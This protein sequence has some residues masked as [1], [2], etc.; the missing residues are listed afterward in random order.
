VVLGPGLGKN[1]ETIETT[2]V[3]IK[4]IEK[5]R[6]PLLLDADGLKAFSGSKR[7]LLCPSV[8]TPHAKEFEILSGSNLPQNLDRKTI[9]VQKMAQKLAATIL[10]KGP[11]DVISNGLE[12]K[13]NFTGNP[14]M[15][16]GGTGDVLSGIVGGLLAMGIDHF[17]AAVAGAFINGAAGDFVNLE[18]G[19]HM[20]PTDL[21]DWI[22]HVIDDPLS[23]GEVYLNRK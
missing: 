11:I 17:D 18:K 19:Y 8:L 6:T 21:L 1:S 13:L 23:H 9:T 14:G 22:P 16:V 5:T 2:N 20:I 3:L 10:L 12:T 7:K 15:T 4:E